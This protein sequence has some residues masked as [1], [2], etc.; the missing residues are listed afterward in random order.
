MS[1]PAPG[2]ILDTTGG[3]FELHDYQLRSG[4]R[5]W[6]V[7]HTGVVLTPEDEVRV[8]GAKTN[9][10]PYGVAL[11]PSAI[12][13]GHEIAGRGDQ[14]AGRRVLELGA[15][16][17]LPGIVASSAGGRVVQTDRDELALHLARR[18][19]ARNHAADVEYRLADWTE[20]ADPDRYD[21]IIGADILYG[22]VL[23][24]H[25]RQIFT[26]NLRPGGRILLADPFRGVGLR[27][28][29]G[30]EAGGWRV[31]YNQWD[32]GGVGEPRPVAVFEL[33][34]PGSTAAPS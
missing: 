28:L 31:S 17:G 3:T 20:W 22:A 11:W 16:M 19:G 8:I 12:A 33:A 13:L 24:D 2:P 15:G 10:L 5:A 26:G 34:P 27:F 29:E 6:S 7:W 18:N 25:L 23:H 9:R 1:Q 32:V 14:F 21:W 30:L 4:A